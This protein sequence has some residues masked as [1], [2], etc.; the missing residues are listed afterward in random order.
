M[1]CVCVCSGALALEA[2][3]RGDLSSFTA[4][5][6][7]TD[8]LQTRHIARTHR[9]QVWSLGVDIHVLDSGGN[10]VDAC[11]LAAL[12][13]LLGFRK[14]QVEVDQSKGEG[15]AQVTVFSPDVSRRWWLSCA[16]TSAD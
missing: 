7:P 4:D 14:P 12:A 5:Q 13:A 3:S 10:L 2:P 8:E 1:W 16:G 9:P 11:C 6:P 15:E